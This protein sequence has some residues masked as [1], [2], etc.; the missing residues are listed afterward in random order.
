MK[1]NEY[2]QLIESRGNTPI[3][4]IDV[5]P[6]YSGIYDGDENPV[7]LNIINFVSKSTGKILM[8]TNAEETGL[9]SDSIQDIKVYWEDSGFYDWNRVEIIDKGYGY[10]RGWMDLGV[11]DNIIIKAIREM[12]QL[13]ISDSRE[14]DDNY[15]EDKATIMWEKKL[16]Y[17]PLPVDPLSVNWISVKKLKQFEGSYMVGGARSQCLREVELIMNAFN[18]RYKRV[19]ALIYD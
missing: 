6:E 10:L 12:Y 8:F 15:D 5:Q 2:F 1:F 17:S 14:I 19:D 13:K 4:V 3:I 18:I 16:N 11:P 7:F 9:T